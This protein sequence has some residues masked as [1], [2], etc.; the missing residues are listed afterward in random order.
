MN[1][2]QDSS[3]TQLWSEVIFYIGNCKWETIEYPYP[4][5]ICSPLVTSQII[6]RLWSWFLYLVLISWTDE[7]VWKLLKLLDTNSINENIYKHGKVNISSFLNKL[8][9]KHRGKTP[10]HNSDYFLLE[11][12]HDDRDPHITV[13]QSKDHWIMVVHVYISTISLGITFLNINESAFAL[14]QF[15]YLLLLESSILSFWVIV[16]KALPFYKPHTSV[17]Y[18]SKPDFLTCEFSQH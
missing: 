13:K 11:P 10:I 6:P 2:I 14:G 12:Y 15:H 7:L 8:L 3:T 18:V 5:I 1:V 9:H 4:K 17:A 16:Q